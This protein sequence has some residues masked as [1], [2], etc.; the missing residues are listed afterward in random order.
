MRLIRFVLAMI[1]CST[2]SLMAMN[3]ANAMN[4]FEFEKEIDFLCYELQGIMGWRKDNCQDYF[5]GEYRTMEQQNETARMPFVLRVFH[6]QIEGTR[7]LCHLEKNQFP[8]F[9]MEENCTELAFS[10]MINL[11]GSIEWYHGEYK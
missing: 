1:V 6:L 4:K 7:I 10:Q 5:R 11:H 9:E 3:G 8:E 2:V